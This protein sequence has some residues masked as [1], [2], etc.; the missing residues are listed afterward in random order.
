MGD[1]NECDTCGEYNY[2]MNESCNFCDLEE[3]LKTVEAERDK[4]KAWH[5]QTCK[6]LLDITGKLHALEKVAKEGFEWCSDFACKKK[7]D[8]CLKKI[9]KLMEKK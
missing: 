9:D 6:E 4:E 3:K 5:N 2:W 7:A 8:D 1:K